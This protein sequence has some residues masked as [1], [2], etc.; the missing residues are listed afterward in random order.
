MFGHGSKH[1]REQT[2]ETKRD[3]GESNV[4]VETKSE[5]MSDFGNRN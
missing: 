1:N 5:A 2:K 4:P 3:T